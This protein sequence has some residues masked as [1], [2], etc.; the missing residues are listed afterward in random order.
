VYVRETDF[1]TAVFRGSQP[2]FIRSRNLN[3]ERTISQEIRLS[4]TYLRDTLQT[5]TIERCY[6]AGNQISAD[7][8]NVLAAEFSAPVVPVALRDF[9]AAPPHISGMDAELTA[10]TG[11]F[12][13]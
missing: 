7:V 10:C 5:A 6:L 3:A 13:G 4:A 11:V 2:M 12:A 9:T 1:T 8:Q